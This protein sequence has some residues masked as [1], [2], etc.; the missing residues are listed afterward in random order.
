MM[1]E[2]TRRF[3]REVRLIMRKLKAAV[4]T[5]LLLCTL[6]LLVGVGVIVWA[7]TCDGYDATCYNKYWANTCC[8]RGCFPYY[9]DP[10]YDVI[11]QFERYIGPWI[12][13]CCQKQLYT[14]YSYNCPDGEPACTKSEWAHL[15][16]YCP[17][18]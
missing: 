12:V 15:S 10:D 6:S 2:M 7:D 14:A 5:W 3:E 11:E 9:F 18:L 4:G 8:T 17:E 16:G 1:S 13:I